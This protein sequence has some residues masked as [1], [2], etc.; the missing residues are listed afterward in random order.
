MENFIKPG[1]IS[2]LDG[3]WIKFMFILVLISVKTEDLR[4]GLSIRSWEI[5]LRKQ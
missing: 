4:L 5:S 2:V 3:D 1:S